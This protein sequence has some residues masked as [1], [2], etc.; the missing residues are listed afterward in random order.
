MYL[1]RLS[2]TSIAF[3]NLILLQYLE[4]IPPTGYHLSPVLYLVNAV[5]IT[6]S[7]F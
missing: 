6:A 5:H 1:M 3:V 7:M 2:G 4:Q